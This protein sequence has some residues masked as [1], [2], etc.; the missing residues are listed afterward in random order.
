MINDSPF[1][2][3]HNLSMI[4]IHRKNI[5]C[6]VT[7]SHVGSHLNFK[8]KIFKLKSPWDEQAFDIIT[9]QKL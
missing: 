2:I 7:M 9:P 3:I 8:S 5:K 4:N 6:D 1:S